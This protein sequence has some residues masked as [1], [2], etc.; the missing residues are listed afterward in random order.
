MKKNRQHRRKKSKNAEK[1]LETNRETTRGLWHPYLV[2]AIAII[3]PG[4]GQLLNEQSTRAYM[5][6]FFMVMGGWVTYHLT[7][8]EHSFVGR[9]A[10]GFF[11]YAVSVMDAYKWARVRWEIF[12]YNS[13]QDGS[14]NAE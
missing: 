14:K 8:P 6:I 10:G 2:M 4:I 11:V 7:T 9:Y 1:S 13:H 3:L 12:Q 5:M